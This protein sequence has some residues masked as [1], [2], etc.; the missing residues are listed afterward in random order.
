VDTNGLFRLSGSS[1]TIQDLR[2][3]YNE[4]KDVTIGAEEDAHVAAG[5]LK[6][7]LREMPI[8]LLPNNLY[9]DFIRTQELEETEQKP[10]IK[11]LVERLDEI[12]RKTLSHIMCFLH[13]VSL[14]SEVNLMNADNLGIVISP[15]ILRR[16]DATMMEIMVESK[17]GAELTK[18]L[19][20]WAPDI[21]S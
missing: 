19:I 4:G 11:E 14:R 5:V 6:L 17:A 3:Q 1:A 7:F 13:R 9:H 15:N 12:N 20:E 10:K 2:Q 21:F 16:D 18:R 8:P